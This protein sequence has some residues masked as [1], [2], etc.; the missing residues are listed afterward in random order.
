M[1]VVFSGGGIKGLAYIGVVQYFE[2]NSI[3]IK[4]ISGT[5][6]GSLIS[7]MLNLGYSSFEMKNIAFN[8]DINMLEN[9]NISLLLK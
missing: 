1:N 3:Q 5:S 4:N 6:I 7:V 9:I 2:E 8:L